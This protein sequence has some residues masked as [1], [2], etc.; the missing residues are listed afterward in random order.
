MCLRQ[1]S[2]PARRPNPRRLD[3]PLTN[4]ARE[5]LLRYLYQSRRIVNQKGWKVF[6]S[7]HIRQVLEIGG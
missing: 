7:V 3:F 4:P 1:P 5:S 2:D 6:V